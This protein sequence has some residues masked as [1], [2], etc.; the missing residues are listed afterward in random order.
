MNQILDGTRLSLCLAFMIYASW[1]DFKKREVSN[2][3]WAIFAPLALALT[4]LQLLM[5]AP[6]LLYVYALSFVVTSAFSI[7]IFYAGAFGGA[8]AK[9]LICLALA[10]PT[11]P[12]HLLRP[13]TGF[14]SPLSFLLFPIA[15]F[16]NAV[17]LASLS[18]FYAILR[19]FLWKSRTRRKFFEGFEKESKW[20]KLLTL[21]CGYKV[22]IV[23]LEKGEHLYPLEDI[24]MVETGKSERK[25]LL[26]PKNE[27]RGEIVERILK[28]A[29]QGVVQ[30][31][32]WV[33]PGLPLIVFVTAGLI[34]ALAFGDVVWFILRSALGLG[35]WR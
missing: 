8:D 2:T 22:K 30:D 9:A 4:S 6:H 28:A 11:Y 34:V 15:T 33:T 20:R 31:E 1:S 13:L 32:V 7:A 25:L 3:L 10:L 5:F 24:R 26:M 27:V 17:L 21:L 18:V 16:C 12:A 14:V 19:N 23:K 29:R 35:S